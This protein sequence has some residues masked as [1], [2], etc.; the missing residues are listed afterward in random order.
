[1]R[2]DDV[3]RA[4]R[5]ALVGEQRRDRLGVGGLRRPDRDGGVG[6]LGHG[7]M[8]AAVS[9]QP[10]R[11]VRGVARRQD[12]RGRADP[13]DR[14]PREPS[15]PSRPRRRPALAVPGQEARPDGPRCRVRAARSS[16]RP[17]RRPRDAGAAAPDRAPTRARWQRAPGRR[18]AQLPRSATPDARQ[19][20]HRRRRA[21]ELDRR[22]ASSDRP[23]HPTQDHVGARI[24][25]HHEPETLVQAPRRDVVGE[26]ARGGSS[27]LP[28]ADGVDH[29]R[30]R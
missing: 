17:A 1:M 16:R 27:S 14:P 26:H 19:L 13:D 6:R 25:A 5:V 22:P 30:S 29:R 20:A 2:S 7:S 3:A 23:A 21:V 11:A 10:E 28:S 8:V 12:A 18:T 15:S 24:A 4:G 9:T